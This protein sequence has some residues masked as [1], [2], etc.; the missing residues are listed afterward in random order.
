MGRLNYFLGVIGAGILASLVACEDSWEEQFECD[1]QFTEIIENSQ[2]QVYRNKGEISDILSS[3]ISKE[4]Q[5]VSFDEVAET[6]IAA[7][8]MCG[9]LKED[10]KNDGTQA[11][12]NP[13]DGIITFN[14]DYWDNFNEDDLFSGTLD[15][16]LDLYS[17]EGSEQLLILDKEKVKSFL[18]ESKDLEQ[19]YME[20]ITDFGYI[21]NWIMPLGEYSTHEAAHKTLADKGLPYRHT[22]IDNP[23]EDNI[24][25]YGIATADFLL[26]NKE[27]EAIIEEAYQEL[28]EEQ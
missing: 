2:S 11:T 13:E 9:Y 4:K 1:P 16:L 17:L 12:Y 19:S 14:N 6:M 24:Y 27:F 15:Q 8:F 21:H 3:Y 5:V 22:D 25:P 7:P 26:V 28:L 20:L 18:K 23:V 10:A